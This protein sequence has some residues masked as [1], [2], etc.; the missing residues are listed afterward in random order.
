MLSMKTNPP[1]GEDLG[2]QFIRAQKDQSPVILASGIAHDFNNI[3]SV[4]I[5]YTQLAM[6]NFPEST[7]LR[8]TLEEVLKAGCRG[9]DLVKQMLDFS[10]RTEC[11]SS[12]TTMMGTVINEAL[13]MLRPMLPPII[14]LRQNIIEDGLVIADPT[15]IHRVIMNL[16]TNAAH[17]MDETGG[18]LE[19]SLEKVCIDNILEA[20]ELNLSPAPYFKLKVRDTGHGMTPEV[21][22]R[23]F[24]PFF[25]TKDPDRGTGLG[26]SVV[27]GIVKSCRGFITCKSTLGEGSCFEIY[28][29]GVESCNV[30]AELP[31]DK[32]NLS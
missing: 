20:R 4:I 23:I 27:H 24:D 15:Q 2:L 22:S 30:L 9:K 21:M 14:E 29:P 13:G 11:V 26:L 18:A 32:S 6:D 5:G 25:S 17:A 16:C 28:L 1:E 8:N 7:D 12:P 10:S 31:E 19:V 3:L